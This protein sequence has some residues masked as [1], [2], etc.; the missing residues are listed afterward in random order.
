MNWRNVL[1]WTGLVVSLPASFF[2]GFNGVLYAWLNA[3]DPKAWPAERAGPWAYGSFA[4]A[5]AFFCLFV[6]C[7]IKIHRSKPKNEPS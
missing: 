5:A 2:I 4:I 6:Y 3:S 1:L 7:V